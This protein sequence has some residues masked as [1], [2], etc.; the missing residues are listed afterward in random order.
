MFQDKVPGTIPY[1][2]GHFDMGDGW[3]YRFSE[4][5]EDAGDNGWEH[6]FVFY[7]FPVNPEHVIPISVGLEPGT[8]LCLCRNFY[9]IT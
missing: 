3:K 2:I 5:C 1:A 9:S 4:N 7:T 6:D 8:V